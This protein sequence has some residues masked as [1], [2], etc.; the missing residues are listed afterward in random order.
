M[1]RECRLVSPSESLVVPDI[2][3]ANGFV[4]DQGRLLVDR[5][6][7]VGSTRLPRSGI[8]VLADSPPSVL[9][10]RAVRLPTTRTHLPS[11]SVSPSES[12]G[13]SEID[14]KMSARLYVQPSATLTFRPVI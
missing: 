14:L 12:R 6:F 13:V 8:A 3:G 11:T 9:T 5:F 1:E 2:L 7:F 10:M 4:A